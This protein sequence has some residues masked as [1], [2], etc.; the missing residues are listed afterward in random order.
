[1]RFEGFAKAVPKLRIDLRLGRS[2]HNM[3]Y[4]TCAIGRIGIPYEM[5][6]AIFIQAAGRKG[7][8]PS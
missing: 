2:G 3:V 4:H 7:A 1:M 8:L 5:F 6:A